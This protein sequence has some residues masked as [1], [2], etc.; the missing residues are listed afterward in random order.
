MTMMDQ[1]ATWTKLLDIA[2]ANPTKAGFREAITAAKIELDVNEPLPGFY[3]GRAVKDGPFLPIAIWIDETGKMNITRG[4]QPVPIPAVWP[5]CVWYPVSHEAFVAVAERGE[6]WPD[7]DAAVAASREDATI[8]DN[9]QNDTRT[10]VE[11]LR[12]QIDIAKAGMADHE[13]ITSDEQAARAQSLRSRLLELSGEADKKREREKAPH[14]EAAKA[15]DAKWQPLV[16]DAKASADAL[17]SALDTYETA[18]FRKQQEEQRK[19]DE[20]L[21]KQAEEAAKNGQPAPVT[22]VVEAEPPKAAPTSI[23]G[24]YGRAAAVKPVKVAK[25]VD[26]AKA[27]AFFSETPEMIEFIAALAQKAINNGQTVPGVDVEEERRVA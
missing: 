11:I 25:V 26:Q 6:K 20:E 18:K 17:R 7:E 24:G 16:K 8:G 2:K 15:V 10:E 9:S 21:R 22:A 13:K 3:R 4:G 12:E 1:Y 19:R 27:Y 23:R 5:H 14:W